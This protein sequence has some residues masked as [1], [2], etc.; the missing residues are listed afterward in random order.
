MRFNRLL[1]LIAFPGKAHGKPPASGFVT[2]AKMPDSRGF[3]VLRPFSPHTYPCQPPG[4]SPSRGGM[5]SG[6][7]NLTGSEVRAQPFTTA[8]VGSSHPQAWFSAP[9]RS[10]PK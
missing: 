6:H 3:P 8:G 7:H 2:A 9:T 10:T 5:I 4:F 1:H